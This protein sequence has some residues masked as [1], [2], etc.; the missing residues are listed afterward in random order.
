M[1]TGHLVG[2]LDR[3]PQLLSARHDH[4]RRDGVVPGTCSGT[5][6][7]GSATANGDPADDLDDDHGADPNDDDHDTSNDNDDLRT[8]LTWLGAGEFAGNGR[9]V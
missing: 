2:L 6:S 9:E 8:R 3:P 7:D 1:G 4:E 5:R